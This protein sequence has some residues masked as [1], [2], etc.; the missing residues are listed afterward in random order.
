MW[1]GTYLGSPSLPTYAARLPCMAADLAWT[2][3]ATLRALPSRLSAVPIRRNF[4][5]ELGS[6]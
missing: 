5:D 3:P 6:L 2:T 4:I 1:Y